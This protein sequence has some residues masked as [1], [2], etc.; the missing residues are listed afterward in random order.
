MEPCMKPVAVKPEIWCLSLAT[1]P[2]L[3]YGFPRNPLREST[4]TRRVDP[5]NTLRVAL[6]YSKQSPKK[7]AG[8][9]LHTSC[10][11]SPNTL[12]IPQNTPRVPLKKLRGAPKLVLATKNKGEKLQIC[13]HWAKTNIFRPHMKGSAGSSTPPQ[14]LQGPKAHPWPSPLSPKPYPSKFPTQNQAD[15]ISIRNSDTNRHHDQPSAKTSV[16]T[17]FLPQLY[18]QQRTERIQ[19]M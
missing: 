7:N 11:Y 16:P 13:T 2:Y 1:R 18:F 3:C 19:E 14:L 8:G 17:I 4:E 5:L 9:N 6:K 12:R 10:R 15:R